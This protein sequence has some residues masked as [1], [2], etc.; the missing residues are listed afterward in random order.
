VPY[1]FVHR[2]A[3]DAPEESVYRTGDQL[4]V[5][6]SFTGDG[7]AIALVTGTRVAQAIAGA[8]PVATY[9]AA[10]AKRLAL[11]MFVSGVLSHA[12]ASP[13][14]RAC[15]VWPASIV[16]GIFSFVAANTRIE[17]HHATP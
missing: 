5:I 7:I 3:G 8:V 2:A 16:P 12:I 14:G 10:M 4:A 15:V 17:R 13:L 9:H 6:P 1:G 11:P